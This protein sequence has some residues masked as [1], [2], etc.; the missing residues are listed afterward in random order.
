VVTR[1]PASRR[2]CNDLDATLCYPSYADADGDGA[3]S[4][5]PLCVPAAPGLVISGGDCDDSDPGIR[6]WATELG[7]DGV[8]SDCDGLDDNSCI[9]PDSGPPVFSIDTSC[10][11]P[12]LFIASEGYCRSCAAVSY[13]FIVGNRG[14]AVASGLLSL[15]GG[16]P[17]DLA[18]PIDLAPGDVLPVVTFN[19]GSLSGG[20]FLRLPGVEECTLENNEVYYSFTACP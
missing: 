1:D 8:D 18:I 19:T 12:D 2:D 15:E 9:D 17:P 16:L 7:A 3:G 20:V 6:P 13:S 10:L 14:T 5:T 11:G 4:P